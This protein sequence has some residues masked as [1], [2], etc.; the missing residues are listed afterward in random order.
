MRFHTASS[1]KAFHILGFGVACVEFRVRV[2]VF[3]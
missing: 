2:R 3:V 1:A